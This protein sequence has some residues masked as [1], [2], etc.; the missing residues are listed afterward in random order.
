MASKEDYYIIISSALIHAFFLILALY[1]LNKSLL[2]NLFLKSY[3]KRNVTE[4]NI[5]IDEINKYINNIITNFYNEIGKPKESN[6][7][8]SSKIRQFVKTKLNNFDYSKIKIDENAEKKRQKNNKKLFK[9]G[10]NFI[11]VFGTLLFSFII[12][13][14][15]LNKKHLSKYNIIVELSIS[16][17]L[18]IILLFSYETYFIY[19]FSFNILNYNIP[20]MI[21]NMFNI[22]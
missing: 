7:D 20:T 13:Y 4:L 21:N 12:I 10:K 16:F 1:I 17:I 22:H 19:S 6:I 11:I 2:P 9:I 8:F 14:Y 3:K 18:T 5:Y 15:I